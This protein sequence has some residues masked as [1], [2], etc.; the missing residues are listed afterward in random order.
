MTLHPIDLLVIVAY[1]VFTLAIGLRFA[2]RNRS[3]DRYF[4]GG[5][6]FPGW[7]IGLSFIGST[8]SSITFIAYPADS[9]KTAWLRI[10]PPLAFPLIVLLAAYA[11]IPFFR[12][13]AARSAYHYLGLRFGP[14]V[15]LYAALV[16]LAMQVTRAATIAYLLSV[17][18]SSMTSLPVAACIALS[19]GV[20]ALYTIKGG[21]EAVVWTDVIQTIVLLSGAIACVLFVAHALPGGMGQVFGEAWAAGKISFRDL[22]PATGQLE[23]VASGFSL[24]EKTAL[25]LVL[26]GAANYL[27]GQLDQD[28]V[29]RWRAARSSRE[30]RRAMFV[31]GFGAI[32]I[33]AGFMFLGTCLWTYYRHFPTDVSA[34]VL[35]GA[36]KAEDILP[37]FIVTVLPHGLTGLV[38]SAALAAAMAS[39]SSCINATSMVW[40]NDI[41]RL[42]VA[43]DKSDAHYLRGSRLASLAIAVLM[44]L[45]AWFFHLASTK[46]IL[47]FILVVT[48]LLGG[49]V[50]AAFVFGMFTRLGDARAVLAGIFATVL[51]TAYSVLVTFGVLPRVF[52]AYYTSILANG[53]MFTTCCVAAFVLPRRGGDLANLTVWDRTPAPASAPATGITYTEPS[54]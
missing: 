8:I 5:R 31:L 48:A 49:G 13:G 7:A 3:T 16:Y 39:L 52:N 9:F 1:G 27:A 47:D 10:L 50:S 40:V 35:G 36:R 23:P 33:W 54:R 34:A 25:M 24:T 2:K 37:H 42:Y 12:H 17:L 41:Y 51:F 18:L 4:L 28:S 6:D 22:N 15:S 29:Q 26:V 32:P 53:I 30:A 45:G 38:I 11:F 19:A 20:T 46:T 43:R 21:F 44:S 14:S